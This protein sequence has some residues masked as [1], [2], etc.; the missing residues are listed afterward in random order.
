[1][2]KEIAHKYGILFV[3]DEVQWGMGKTGK[4]WCI[5]HWD[6]VPDIIT[7]AKSLA[8][9]LPL[10][11]CIADAK[12]MDWKPGAH[13]TTFGG[14]PL[15][16]AAAIETIRLLEDG[17]MKNAKVMGDYC[18]DQLLAMQKKHKSMGDVRGLGLLLAVEFV[19]DKKTKEPAKAM[20][21]DIMMRCF[22]SGLMTLT[23]GVSGIRLC[24]PLIVNKATIDQGI[25]IFDRVITEMEKKHLK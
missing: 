7:T 22:E 13:S 8:S 9:G 21:N 15:A 20:A 4:M 10:G 1:M 25:A 24:P 11:A 12:L 19:L 6:V 23:C 18:K 5:E 14:N 2:L 17:L 16:C 3:S